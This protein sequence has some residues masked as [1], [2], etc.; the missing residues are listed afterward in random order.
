[1]TKIGVPRKY[2]L[3]YVHVSLNA[4]GLR[5]RQPAWA[6]GAAGASGA[7]GETALGTQGIA[8]DITELVLLRDFTRE[9]QCILPICSVCRRIRVKAAGGESWVPL[10]EYVSLKSTILFSHTFCPDHLPQFP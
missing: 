5:W 3:D 6:G 10:D 2:D 7:A 8:R 9:V 1:M 4:F